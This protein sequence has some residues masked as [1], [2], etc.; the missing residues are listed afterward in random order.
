MKCKIKVKKKFHH[1]DWVITQSLQNAW[2]AERRSDG[3]F[4]Y[5]EGPCRNMYVP[6]SYVDILPESFKYKLIALF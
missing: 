4:W 1:L 6:D 2:F 3:L 5:L